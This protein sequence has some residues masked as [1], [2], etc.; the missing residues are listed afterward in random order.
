ME[1]SKLTCRRKKGGGKKE[2]HFIR[3]PSHISTRGED[4]EINRKSRDKIQPIVRQ[5][6]C[7][8]SEWR[9]TVKESQLFIFF[10]NRHI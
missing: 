3:L 1:T 5:E 6:A 7:A 4:R 9:L 10:V 8:D 2:T